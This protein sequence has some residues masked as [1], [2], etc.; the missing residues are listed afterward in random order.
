MRTSGSMSFD[1]YN[2]SA[3]ASCGSVFFTDWRITLSWFVFI[4]T[5]R[6]TCGTTASIELVVLQRH[7]NRG[8]DGL[9][10]E[11]AGHSKCALWIAKRRRR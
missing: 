7:L 5:T 8:V 10:A 6:A 1:K 11:L 3:R 2:A 9:L 4:H